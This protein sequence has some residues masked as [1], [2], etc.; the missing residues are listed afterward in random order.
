MR[1]TARRLAASIL[2]LLSTSILVAQEASKLSRA[3]REFVKVDAPLLALTHVR[4]IDGTGA[5]PLEDQTLVV[6]DERIEALGST[7]KTAAA[8]GA[9]VLDLPG[10]T[11][12]PGLVGMHDHLFYPAKVSARPPL[13]NEMGFSAPRLYLACGITT[14]RTT[15]GGADM[16]FSSMSA[17]SPWI[18]CPEREADRAIQ[19]KSLR[20]IADIKNPMSAPPALRMSTKPDNF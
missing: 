12:I 4:V 2:I 20:E 18:D 9:K 13:Y 10:Y 1:K 11:V 5:P 16:C 3:V 17:I 6:K 19:N 14:I 15:A 8:P 7:E